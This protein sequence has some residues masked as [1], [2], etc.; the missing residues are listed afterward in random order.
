MAPAVTTGDVTG[1]VGVLLRPVVA[2]LDGTGTGAEDELGLAEDST[3]K[4]A[5][6]MRVLLA[7]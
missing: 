1:A 5:H 3:L 4:L 2:E 7:K 6:E